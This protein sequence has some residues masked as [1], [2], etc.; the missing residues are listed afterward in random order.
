MLNRFKVEFF[1][2][3]LPSAEVGAEKPDEAIFRL[4]LQRLGLRPE[5]VAHVGDQYETDVIGARAVG[6]TP[7]LLDREG[8]ARYQDVICISSLTELTVG[9][10][11]SS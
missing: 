1:A 2:F 4:A 11:S 7:I 9:A 8:K 5:E 3:I 6:I 10:V